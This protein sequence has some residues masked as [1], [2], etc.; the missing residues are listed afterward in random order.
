LEY[1]LVNKRYEVGKDELINV[2]KYWNYLPFNICLDVLDSLFEEYDIPYSKHPFGIKEPRK[3]EVQ[4]VIQ[5]PKIK[6]K[7]D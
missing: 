5:F 4:K 3:K 2:F 1:V 7:E 6:P